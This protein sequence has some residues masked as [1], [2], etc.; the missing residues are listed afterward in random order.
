MYTMPNQT[1]NF[2][3]HH[4]LSPITLQIIFGHHALNARFFDLHLFHTL[5]CDCGMQAKTSF[6]SF[7]LANCTINKN[8]S[9]SVPF[10]TFYHSQSL[11][12]HNNSFHS[13]STSNKPTDFLHTRNFSELFFFSKKFCLEKYL[14][15]DGESL[16]SNICARYP[17]HRIWSAKLFAHSL[18]LSHYY[19]YFQPAYYYCYY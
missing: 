7:S 10:R 2:Q 19:S 1:E 13:T 18:S 15:T 3:H 12:L 5:M 6:H 8:V 4:K 11:S 9:W 16:I 17:N 14:W